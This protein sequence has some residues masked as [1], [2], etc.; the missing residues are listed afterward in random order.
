MPKVLGTW[1]IHNAIKGLKDELDFFLM[2]SSVSG[3]IGVATEANYCAANYFLDVFARYRLSIGLPAVSIGIGM[4]S[5]IGYLHEHPDIQ[6]SL[7][8]KGVSALDEDD[9]LQI[10][11]AALVSSSAGHA[12]HNYGN[13]SR[14]HI[15]TGLEPSG[16][17]ELRKS[18]F[19]GTPATFDDPRAAVINDAL[20]GAGKK[21]TSVLTAGLPVEV[22]DAFHNGDSVHDAALSLIA[23]QFSNFLLTPLDKL[24]TSKP[25]AGFGMDSVLAAA[26]RAW[27]YRQFQVDI[28]FMTLLSQ[29]ASI[30]DLVETIT[31]SVIHQMELKSG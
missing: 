8:Q 21:G 20:Q 13:F 17:N 25:L 24:D 11:D 31:E 14:G 15:L 28:A 22:V 10:V 1:N 29:T 18:G 19:E 23:R 3:S 26:V 12:E 27:L 16:L 4:M 5:Q 9:F 6:H 7:A 2:T 30:K